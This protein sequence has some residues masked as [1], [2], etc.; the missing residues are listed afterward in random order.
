MQDAEGEGVEG[1]AHVYLYSGSGP[2]SPPSL[3][4]RKPLQ[5]GVA[6]ASQSTEARK[7]DDDRSIAA[8]ERHEHLGSPDQPG[9]GLVP[10]LP[11][12]L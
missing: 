6:T 12:E 2:T 8:L 11:R 1:Q 7:P 4:R 5:V 3:S 10:R 9:R